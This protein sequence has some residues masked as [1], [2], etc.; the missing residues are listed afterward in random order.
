MDRENGESTYVRAGKMREKL[1]RVS[2][3]TRESF[4]Q[5]VEKRAEEREREGESKDG[6]AVAGSGAPEERN[7]E[8]E[9]SKGGTDSRNP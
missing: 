8:T 5:R 3:S 6:N 7:R 9:K 1:E 4:F 2:K